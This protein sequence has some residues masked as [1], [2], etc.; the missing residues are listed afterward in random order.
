MADADDLPDSLKQLIAAWRQEGASTAEIIE[1]LDQLE[2]LAQSERDR[3]VALVLH[4]A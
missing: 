2:L 3:L 1:R 4:S